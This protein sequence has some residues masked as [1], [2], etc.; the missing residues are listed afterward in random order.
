MNEYFVGSVE[1]KWGIC[2]MVIAN[3]QF[4][5]STRQKELSNATH[6]S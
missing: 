4:N 2:L 5:S 1:E 6:A 3:Q